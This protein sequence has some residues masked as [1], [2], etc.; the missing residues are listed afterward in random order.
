MPRLR[1]ILPRLVLGMAVGLGLAELAFRV[2]DG[3]GFPHINILVEDA[4]LGVRMLPDA[5]GAI[6]LG[7]NPR[8]AYST[9]PEGWRTG[10]ALSKNADSV[11]VV[12]DSQVFGLGV[13]DAHTVAAQL[14]VALDRP[15]HNGGVPTYGPDEYLA[16]MDELLTAT[17]A[18]TAVLV[19]NFSNDMFEL[20]RPNRERHAVWDGW[21]V[22]IETAPDDTLEFPGRRWLMSQSHLVFGARRWWHQEAV[23]EGASL[24]SEGD[25]QDVLAH[26]VSTADGAEGGLQVQIEEAV[27]Q[28]GSAKAELAE[29]QEALRWELA[30]SHEERMMLQAIAEN[31]HP[32]DIVTDRASEAARPVT[33]TAE[34]LREGARLAKRL[35][36]Q[37][38]AR[39]A[40]RPDDAVSQKVQAKQKALSSADDQLAA[41]ARTVEAATGHGPFS[42][43][44][45]TAEEIVERHHAE[46][47]VV[48]LPLDVQIDPARFASYGAAEQDMSE[49]L[50]L[51]DL[52][53]DEARRRGHRAVSLAPALVA[54][55]GDL[56]LEG[57]LHLNARGQQIAAEAIAEVVQ[58]PPPARAPGRGLAPGRS[59]VP[60]AIEWT[61]L[62][63][64]LVRGSTR[65]HCQTFRL[66]EWQRVH[67]TSPEGGAAVLTARVEDA[68]AEAMVL[69]MADLVDVVVPVLPGREARILVKWAD[70]T[71]RL[72]VPADGVPAFVAVD[73]NG[74]E[75][76][77]E[78]VEMPACVDGL[79]RFGDGAADCSAWT[80]CADRWSCVQGARQFLPQCEAG[81]AVAGAGLFCQVLCDDV[82]PCTV[83]TC[84]A[85]DGGAFCQ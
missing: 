62:T 1:S 28:R 68:P 20:G 63:E 11:V 16:V 59:R 32:G 56:H 75:P 83:G 38:D 52:L 70:R 40:E 50:V 78:A 5:S 30:S 21:A 51:L 36:P 15:V 45:D 43:M 25:W 54:A 23:P 80:A 77:L 6:T 34:M 73:T 2:R 72:T 29:L 71:E 35:Q 24:P 4:V 19:I 7:D 44:L 81:E 58:Q 76:W 9:G 13:D 42:A 27:Q 22:R 55:G 18:G 57:D 17:G 64:N 3:F 41:L 60:A 14:G 48:A 67:C 66:R 53:V 47:V 79:A 84:A 26:T 65:N 74:D 12:G 37:V 39:L 85:W 49:T 10:A 8:A 46:L 33:V 82:H 69:V 61:A 31:A